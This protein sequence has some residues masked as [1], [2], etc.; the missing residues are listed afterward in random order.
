MV[1]NG[2]VVE[3]SVPVVVALLPNVVEVES[4]ETVKVNVVAIAAVTFTPFTTTTRV[5]AELSCVPPM[6]MMY[7]PVLVGFTIVLPKILSVIVPDEIVPH[8]VKV[9]R[10]YDVV[11]IETVP[12]AVPQLATIDMPVDVTFASTVEVT[13]P[14]ALVVGSNV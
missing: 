1:P 13:L 3:L 8:A 7:E 2:N 12:V 4:G 9:S 6:R 5:S 10:L 11:A 14:N